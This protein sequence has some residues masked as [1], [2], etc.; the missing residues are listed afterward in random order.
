MATRAIVLTVLV[1]LAPGRLWAAGREPEII[2]ELDRSRIYHG[3]S[4]LYQ[5]TL[6]HLENPSPPE[7]PGFD[8]FEVTRLGEQSLD[9]R[10]IRIINGR[11]TE[12][13]RLGRQ[14]TYR[15]RDYP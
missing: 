2:V 11:R 4:V 5:V 13:I 10:V 6:N 7:L 9:S 14:Y 15:Q 12:T 8:D 1:V 3:E